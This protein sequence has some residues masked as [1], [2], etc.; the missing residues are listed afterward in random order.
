ML[1][2]V[3]GIPIE[4]FVMG[5][6]ICLGNPLVPFLFLIAV[7]NL[8]SMSHKAV[9]N[10]DFTRYQ[11]SNGLKFYILQF[12]HDVLLFGKGASENL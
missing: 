11:V 12:A 10:G 5:R 8:T 3:N 1:V 7:E 2:L 9:Q 6:G 4:E